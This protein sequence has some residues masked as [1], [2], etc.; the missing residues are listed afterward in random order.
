MKITCIS[1][2]NIEVARHHSA[3]VR[4]CELIRD[5]IVKEYP[6]AE[7]EIVP[8]IDY[9]LKSCRMCGKCLKSE[10]C[11][12]DKDFNQVFEK[13]IDSDG[14]FFIVPHYAPLP[15]KLMIMFEKFE[16][17]GYLSWC[18]DN[19][20][21][22][23]LMQKPAGVIGHGGQ[24]PTEEVLAY[25]QRM[26]VEPVASTLS[27]VGMRVMGAGEGRPNGVT[28]GIRSLRQ[29]EGEVFVEIE[30]DW[31]EIRGRIAPLV[32]NVAAAAILN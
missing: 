1:A 28:F 3:S 5:Q 30:H 24:L 16:E 4:T 20:Y 31:E 17:I 9:K 32:T 10:R 19:A 27:A 29:P 21:R 22:F 13:L 26:L 2:A 6:G 11:A 25:Y 7:V 18:A 23:P 12:H 15:S 8:L 14:I